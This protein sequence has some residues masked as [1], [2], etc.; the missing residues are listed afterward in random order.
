MEP[1]TLVAAWT[2]TRH[3][4]IAAGVGSPVLDARM[5]LEEAAGVSRLE[6]VTDPYRPV[7]AEV[8]A[9]LEALTARR[10]AREPL[11][12]I[13]GRKD[14]WT[15][16][17]AVSSAVLTPRP[18]TETLVEAALAAL[19]PDRAA[20]VLDL[21]VGS[22][23]ILLAVLSERPLAQGVGVDKSVAALAVAQANAQRLGLADRAELR[24]GDWDA[25][26]EG[27]FDLI[28][29]NP[30]YIASDVI[31]GLMPEVSRHEPL[32]AL[33]GGADGLDAYRRLG[34]A[35]RRLLAPGGR[36]ALE[37]GQGQE[38]Q[39][40]VLLRGGGLLPEAV[41]PDLAGIGRVVVGAAPD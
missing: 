19:P 31:P 4:L 22:G 20:R 11:S 30:P 7:G 10:V 16:S 28:L 38:A 9:R 26:L 29:S 23:A 36:F 5:L 12:H 3:A 37:I 6:I 13:L 8:R 40:I 33:D 35:L 14:F 1:D 17:L 32:L 21:G 34:P 24:E 39:V 15:L 27:P 18:E 25:G 41:R 2:R